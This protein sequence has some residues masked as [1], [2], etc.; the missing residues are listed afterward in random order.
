MI[1]GPWRST[2]SRNASVES[3]SR[4]LRNRSRSSSS[5]GLTSPPRLPPS[6]PPQT[7]KGG[8]RIFDA[9]HGEGQQLF[10]STS[11]NANSWPGR[12]ADVSAAANA[13]IVFD[14]YKQRHNRNSI[15][16]AGGTMELVVNFKS[17]FNNAFWNGQFMIFG[18]GD[19]N[20]FSDL[21]GA[22]D[23]TAHDLE[24]VGESLRGEA[25]ATQ[26]SLEGLDL[27]GGPVGEV[28]E[29]SLL[30]L[31]TLAVGLAQQHGGAGVAIG[32]EVDK[33]GHYVQCLIA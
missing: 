33:H 22:L 21:A 12:A 30:D 3:W 8:I 14:Y 11:T 20:A 25:G 18:N 31:V 9:Q 32:H 23:A 29:G 19:G 26:H 13:S 2:R 4:L 7:V 5:P 10:F 17:N 28:C 6:T 24:R 1:I 16:G 15:D 27:V